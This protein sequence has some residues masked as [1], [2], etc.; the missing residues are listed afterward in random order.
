MTTSAYTTMEKAQSMLW[1]QSGHLKAGLIL[2]K[3]LDR[4]YLKEMERII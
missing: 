3:A 4:M 2:E 1:G